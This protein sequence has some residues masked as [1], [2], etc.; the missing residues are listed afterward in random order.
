MIVALFVASAALGGFA[1]GIVVG[2]W[3][4]VRSDED[5]LEPLEDEPFEDPS[6]FVRVYRLDDGS[7]I[8]GEFLP[9]EGGRSLPMFEEGK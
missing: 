1:V 4:K 3:L 5:L 8:G 9:V 7:I 2:V 6:M